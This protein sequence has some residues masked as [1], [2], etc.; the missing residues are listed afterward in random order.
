MTDMVN[1]MMRQDE[2]AKREFIDAK[3]E[4]NALHRQAL[5]QEVRQEAVQRLKV[6]GLQGD[7]VP[8]CGHDV[9]R[10]CQLAH[11]IKQRNGTNLFRISRT[12]N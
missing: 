9:Y 1:M 6:L 5:R 4:E 8:P 12:G 10:G 11:K 7:C 3:R 2:D